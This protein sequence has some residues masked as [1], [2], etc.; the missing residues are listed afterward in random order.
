LR[1]RARQRRVAA[2]N[3]MVACTDASMGVVPQVVWDDCEAD[4]WS[5]VQVAGI[6]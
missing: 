6:V 2:T 4:F 3:R 1:I 5:E